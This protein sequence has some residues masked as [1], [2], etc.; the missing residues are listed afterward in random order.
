[1]GKDINLEP[2][3]VELMR[4]ALKSGDRLIIK[5]NEKLSLEH[6][7]HLQVGLSQ[8]LSGSGVEVFFINDLDMEVTILEKVEWTDE[9]EAEE[10]VENP[11]G[12]V[13]YVNAKVKKAEDES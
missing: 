4:M 13:T 6:W 10:V 12:S 8:F 11:D 1:M 2:V 5:I 9:F 7:N 3:Q